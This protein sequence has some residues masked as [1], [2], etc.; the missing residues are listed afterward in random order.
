M[1]AGKGLPSIAL[2]APRR[3]SLPALAVLHDVSLDP[4]EELKGLGDVFSPRAAPFVSVCPLGTPLYPGCH[5]EG[6]GPRRK[7][8]GLA[9]AVGV[10]SQD[11]LLLRGP[12]PSF[13]A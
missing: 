6:C 9:Q 13:E 2:S 3:V 8:S 11:T 5:G 12:H 4:V 10:L 1:G 7:G